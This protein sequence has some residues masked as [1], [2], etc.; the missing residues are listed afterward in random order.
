MRHS[1]N[2]MIQFLK[3]GMGEA[4]FREFQRSP[5]F[6]SFVA[7]M[8]ETQDYSTTWERSG[9]AVNIPIMAYSHHFQVGLTEKCFFRISRI[10]RKF[11]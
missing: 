3:D 8:H 10:P 2:T 1:L 11:K 9:Q 4:K 7:E 5:E 6:P